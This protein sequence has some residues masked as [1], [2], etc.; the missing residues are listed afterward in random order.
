MVARILRGGITVGEAGAV[1]Y[2]AGSIRVPRQSVLPA[3]V[4]GV[5]LI[6]VQ[7]AEAIAERKIG[8]PAIDVAES[9]SQLIRI[10]EINL[11]AIFDARGTQCQFPA[12]DAR[13]L[14][15]YGNKQL[16]ILKIIMVKEICGQG[17]EIVCVDGPAAEGN[18][19]A[20]L[21]FFVALAV[22]RNEAQV[23]VGGELQQRAGD[24]LQRRRLI[25][26]AVKS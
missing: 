26:V 22:Q 14:N 2:V 15:G 6:V 4:Q 11:R 10:G 3:D 16:G 18:G 20:E 17:L 21:V 23:L 8:E 5:A 1:V 24:G 7:Q 25:K 12:F 13:A 9:Q 19:D